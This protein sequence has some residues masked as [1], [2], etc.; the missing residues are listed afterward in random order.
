MQQVLAARVRLLLSP[1]NTPLNSHS[2]FSIARAAT[3]SNSPQRAGDESV[4]ER[5]IPSGARRRWDAA[6]Q[7]GSVLPQLRES[8][9]ALLSIGVLKG[10]VCEQATDHFV[11]E[12]TLPD[13]ENGTTG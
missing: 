5:P 9:P 11:V 10:Q 4:K 12:A 7:D 13:R 3:L 1:Q 2:A 6:M 8:H